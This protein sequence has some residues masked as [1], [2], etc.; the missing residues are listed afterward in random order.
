MD[1]FYKNP[2]YNKKR[3]ED[4]IREQRKTRITLGTVMVSGKRHVFAGTYSMRYIKKI[5]KEICSWG[6]HVI[7][8]NNDLFVA[9]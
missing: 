7:R 4:R 1:E 9:K 5:A 6:F 2:I 8:R 3:L